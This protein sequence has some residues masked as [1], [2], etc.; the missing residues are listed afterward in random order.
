VDN[1]IIG[2]VKMLKR[3]QQPT[4]SKSQ[5]QTVVEFSL[6]VEAGC[7]H[8]AAKMVSEIL[9]SIRVTDQVLTDAKQAVTRAMEKELS[10]VL[11]DQTQRTFT[12]LI[13]TQSAQLLETPANATGRRELDLQ[14]KGWGFFLTEKI[15]ND[16]E[17]GNEMN[18]VVMSLHLYQEGHQA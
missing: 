6:D 11:A 4:S 12:V 5:W 8:Q 10:R 14:P 3:D 1:G 16:T 9:M 18:H 15:M 13:M 17:L 7:E 2:G